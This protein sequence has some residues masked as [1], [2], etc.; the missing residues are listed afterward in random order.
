MYQIPSTAGG[1][2][3]RCHIVITRTGELGIR[4]GDPRDLK[5]PSDE[6]L[7]VSS[8]GYCVE[9]IRPAAAETGIA[10]PG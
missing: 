10:L 6:L 5:D 9:L 7:W 8:P 1:Y 2:R 3:S 4:F